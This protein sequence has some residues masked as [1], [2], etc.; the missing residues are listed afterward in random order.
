[1]HRCFATTIDP[2]LRALEPRVVVEVGAGHGRLT[3]RL[4][5]GADRATIHAVDP[6]LCAGLAALDAAEPRLVV[7]TARGADALGTLPAADLLLLDGDP[8]WSTVRAE[9]GLAVAAARAAGRPAPVVVVHGV[10]WPFGRRDGYG[11]AETPG[12][13]ARRPSVRAG[14]LPGRARPA[15]DGLR[16]AAHV[17][18]EEG[19]ARNG[20]LT[21]LEDFVAEDA[22]TW[23]LVD[24]PGYGGSAVL[25]DADRM[26]H[27]PGLRQAVDGLLATPA[28]L[29]LARRVEAGRIEAE[30]RADG[31]RG[32]PGARTDAGPGLDD[33][34]PEL[35]SASRRV[36]PPPVRP[37]PTQRD[38][39]PTVAALDALRAERDDLV[40]EV[41][42][43]A[44][45]RDEALTRAEQGD[46]AAATA[47]RQ[48]GELR[49]EHDAGAARIAAAD[50]V[51]AALRAELDGE[52]RELSAASAAL[53]ASE[54]TRE[55]AERRV[56]ELTEAE[57]LLSGRTLHLEDALEA[58]QA[59]LEDARA[60]RGQLVQ[61]VAHREQRHREALELLAG[62]RAHPRVRLR[63]RIRRMLGMG[64]GGQAAKLERATSLLA[65]TGP[66]AA[67]LDQERA[68]AAYARD[69]AR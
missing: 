44:T 19:G 4:L 33:A 37:D 38:A 62:L 12:G 52:R 63:A 26:T 30:L 21:A 65:P 9:L 17:A 43:L 64:P 66:T 50:A 3:A 14:L 46:A 45:A 40:A 5:R 7:H 67:A 54:R 36:D 16:L 28:L 57:R 49:A 56:A 23:S 69:E 27:T 51:A 1:M 11:S 59:E 53:R 6:V 42:R 60:E 2:L 13:A 35:R 41:A 32:T 8:N 34:G 20:V 29:R 39:G 15:A 24:V 68:T 31:A 58:T 25:A 22:G 61:R 18:M 10:H 48:A 55:E 47:R